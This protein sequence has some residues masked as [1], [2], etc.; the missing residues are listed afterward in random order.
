MN[1][2]AK[3]FNKIVSNQIHHCLE[4]LIHH[5][6]P[7]WIQAQ[8]GI[9]KK[10]YQLKY[11]NAEKVSYR[12]FPGGLMV[13]NL[14]ASSEDTGRSLVWELRSHK[15]LGNQARAPRTHALQ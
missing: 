14:P 9:K 1:T 2:D 7:L 10:Y 15:L 3:V 8:K 6:Y 4:T 11:I 12:N 13:K 5:E